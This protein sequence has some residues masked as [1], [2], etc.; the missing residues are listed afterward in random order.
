[1]NCG[2][3]FAGESG[4]H[5]IAPCL[6][7]QDLRPD[8]DPLDGSCLS[9]AS[10]V[11]SVFAR[12]GR[13]WSST[14][15]G[16]QVGRRRRRRRAVRRGGPA[17][18]ER[19]VGFDVEIAELIAD[20]LGRPPEFVQIA[21]TSLD[22]SAARGDFDIGLSGIEDTPARRAL[23]RRHDAVLRIPR[24]AHG[25][26]RGRDRFRSLADLRGRRVATLGGTTAYELLLAAERE[27]GIQPV[28]YD[29]DVHPYER[30]CERPRRRRAA[31]Q[32]DRRALDAPHAGAR[33]AARRLSRSGHYVGI[34][35]PAQRGA[36]GS[37]RRHPAA[38][39]ARRPARNDPAP[40]ARVER[41]SAE[42]VRAPARS[43]RRMRRRRAPEA[44]PAPP[45]RRVRRGR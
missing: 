40:L 3:G 5:R 7:S 31:R 20:E 10:V 2:L 24:G 8:C 6:H 32:R 37:R 14:A 19:V 11:V 12:A 44:P 41:R 16:V 21:F 36:A 34:L 23:A 15:A 35:A 22:Q 4:A 28:S 38:S 17:D 9:A 25:A 18:P 30:P 42:A 29:D 26:R 45:E 27:H 33:H 43:A 39:D 1:M 13:K